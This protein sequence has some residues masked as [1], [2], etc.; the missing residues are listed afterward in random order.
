M[1]SFSNFSTSNCVNT[2]CAYN[3]FDVFQSTWRKIF[4]LYAVLTF[5]PLVA[6]DFRKLFTHPVSQ[7]WKG[8][9]STCQSALFLAT[10]CALYQTAVCIPRPLVPKDFR[11]A[12]WIAGIVSSM[13]ILIEKKSGRAELALYVLPRALDSLYMILSH[14]KLMV[15]VPHGELLLFCFSLSGIMYFF[16]HEPNTMSPLLHWLITKILGRPSAGKK[17]VNH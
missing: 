14:K 13:S 6:L 17:G 2:S 7:T 12:Y 11:M 8:L 5:A 16:E 9:F 15:S 10:F 1:N 3:S 4:P